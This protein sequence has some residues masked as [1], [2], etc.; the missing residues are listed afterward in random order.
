MKHLKESERSI[1]R[2]N[3]NIAKSKT[4]V[5]TK[6]KK[7]KVNKHSPKI[8]CGITIAL[9]LLFTTLAVLFSFNVYNNTSGNMLNYTDKGSIDYTVNYKENEFYEEP[10]QKSKKLYPAN[11]VDSIDL[12][13]NYNLHYDNAVEYTY[14]Y[15]VNADLY[16]TN[17][18]AKENEDTLIF[19][20]KEELIRSEVKK[21]VATDVKIN[22]KLSIPYEKYNSIAKAFIDE[23]G[24]SAEC[25]LDI[26]FSVDTGGKYEDIKGI[27]KNTNVKVKIPLCEKLIDINESAA[28]KEDHGQFLSKGIN[29]HWLVFVILMGL[30]AIMFLI[31]SIKLAISCIPKLSP[32]EKKMKDIFRKY[33]QLIVKVKGIVNLD[34]NIIEVC[35]FEDLVNASDRILQPIKFYEIE[36]NE[37]SVFVIDNMYKE[38]YVYYIN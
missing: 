28:L 22:E 8:K 34:N 23:Q 12:N 38:Q 10:V 17:K 5:K 3:K 37:K 25:Y 32:Y 6:E 2:K 20:D 9:T 24:I 30:I 7:V 16:I 26:S 35:T 1:K 27:N 11:L 21:G 31:I 14:K 36:K 33:D 13:L 29:M 4:K 18:N 19:E 15:V